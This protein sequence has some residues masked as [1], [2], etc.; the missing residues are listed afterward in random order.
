M[1]LLRRRA[2][3]DGEQRS[4]AALERHWHDGAHDDLAGER[5]CQWRQRRGLRAVR[6]RDNDDIGGGDLIYMTGTSGGGGGSGGGPQ[7]GGSGGGGNGGLSGGS[8]T[9][10]TD[11]NSP[12][13][14][15]NLSNTC[16][17]GNAQAASEICHAE[18]GGNP[19]ACGDKTT[20]GSPVSCGLYQINLT[21][22]NVG[23]LDCTS[24]FDSQYTGKHH[25]VNIVDPTLYNQCVAAAQDP[26]N[27]IDAA[28]SIS[29]N[30]TD[31]RQWSTGSKCGLAV[32]GTG[33][34]NNLAYIP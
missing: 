6:R 12:C 21:N 11:P 7:G 33:G 5:A 22:H 13:S 32:G 24:A 16:F 19:F 29:K 26:S 25:D 1:L 23:G 9:P 30:G 10:I 20:S 17:D 31:W 18:S 28:C 14:V 8:C 4:L 27:N 34:E 3:R 2:L 15:D